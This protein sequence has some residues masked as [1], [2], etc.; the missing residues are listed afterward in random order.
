MRRRGRSDSIIIEDESG[1]RIK[2]AD[3]LMKA[4]PNLTSPG[5][6]LEYEVTFE[7]GFLRDVTGR[8]IKILAFKFLYDVII[9]DQETFSI[10]GERIAKAILKDV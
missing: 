8:S 3:E 9:T 7:S 6:N 10:E 4:L 5:T 2:S 1:N